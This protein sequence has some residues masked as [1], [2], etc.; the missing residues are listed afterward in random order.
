M[1]IGRSGFT[2]TGSKKKKRSRSIS[3]QRPRSIGEARRPELGFRR[4]A[5]DG[6]DGAGM[7]VP[8]KKTGLVKGVFIP[9]DVGRRVWIDGAVV[10]AE[11]LRC[12]FNSSP[13]LGEAAAGCG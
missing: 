3:I 1:K 12:S 2:R 7:A 5:A 9:R 13:E 11:V 8:A 6:G 10:G 4:A